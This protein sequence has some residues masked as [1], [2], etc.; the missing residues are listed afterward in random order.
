MLRLHSILVPTDFSEHAARALA[1]AQA[2]AGSYQARLELL[3]VL[4]EPTFPSFYNLGAAV[5]DVTPGLKDEA[6]AA[7]EK[8]VAEVGTPNV[9]QGFGCHVKQGRTAEEIIRFAEAFDVDLIVIA[10]HGLTGLE[11]L[12]F[13]SVAEKVVRGAPCPILVV[14]AFGKSLLA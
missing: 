5:Y 9:E 13:G 2:L 14:K 6:Q 11:R 1:H 7:L 4:V 8:L 3:H 10:S 12:L